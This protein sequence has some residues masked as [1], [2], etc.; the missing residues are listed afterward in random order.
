MLVA[1]VKPNQRGW[2]TLKAIEKGSNTP[3]T[4]STAY[5]R[6]RHRT[7]QLGSY[8]PDSTF[9][10]AKN[11]FPCLSAPSFGN[12]PITILPR[13][14]PRME[15]KLHVLLCNPHTDWKGGGQTNTLTPHLHESRGCVES[16]SNFVFLLL[17]YLFSLL[18]FCFFF[19]AVILQR[20][21]SVGRVVAMSF[22]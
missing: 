16:A 20:G 4:Y 14:S 12:Q 6:D 8:S 9:E 19:N 15:K 5:Q 10:I 1:V 21:G 13:R 18:S 3:Q 11:S 7:P 17:L 22:H 2:W